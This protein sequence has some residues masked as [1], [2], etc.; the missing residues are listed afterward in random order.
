[1]SGQEKTIKAPKMVKNV[2]NYSNLFSKGSRSMFARQLVI[3]FYIVN[4]VVKKDLKIA[5]IWVKCPKVSDI[6]PGGK[7]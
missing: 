7:H 4:K 1:M 6:G 3:C 2:E 5:K